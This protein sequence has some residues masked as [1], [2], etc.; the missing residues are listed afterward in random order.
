MQTLAIIFAYTATFGV[1]VL[2]LTVILKAF[3][4]FENKYMNYISA[5]TLALLFVMYAFDTQS[6]LPSEYKDAYILTNN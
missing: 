6:M 4:G 1:L 3:L 5:A 2:F